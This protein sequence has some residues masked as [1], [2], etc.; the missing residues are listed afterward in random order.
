M[1]ETTKELLCRSLR[2]LQAQGKKISIKAVADNTGLSHSVIYNRHPELKAIIKLAQKEQAELEDR[3]D[4]NEEIEKLRIKLKAAKR[5]SQQ[6]SEEN[7]ETIPNLLAH[8][9]QVYSMYDQLLEEKSD[10]V[11]ELSRLKSIDSM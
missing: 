7:A 10:C 6:S 9:Q 8:L 2:E 11:R 4:A 5:K 3:R 1:S